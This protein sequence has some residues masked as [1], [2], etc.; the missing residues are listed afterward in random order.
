MFAAFKVMS[1]LKK[2]IKNVTVNVGAL[3]SYRLAA[4]SID[5][6]GGVCLSVCVC[7]RFTV[8]RAGRDV[9]FY[10]DKPLSRLIQEAATAA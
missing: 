5:A 9:F 4:I 6:A 8:S 7:H 3:C 1:T 10:V 2:S